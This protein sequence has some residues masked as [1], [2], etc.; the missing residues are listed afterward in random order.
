MFHDAHFTDLPMLLGKY[1][2]E[3]TGFPICETL[4]IPYQGVCYHL[5]EWG[6]ARLWYVILI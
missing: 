3:D 6:C 1:Y 5:V 2:L 4:L